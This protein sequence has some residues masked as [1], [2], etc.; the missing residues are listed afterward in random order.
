MFDL[1][2]H[3]SHYSIPTHAMRYASHLARRLDASLTAM[4]VHE[5]FVPIGPAAMTAPAIPEI[6]AANQCV[7]D[8]AIAAEGSF[9]RWAVEQGIEQH[10]W[11]VAS[12]SFSAAL[13]SAANWHDALILECGPA[14]P[15]GAVAPLGHALLT[16]GAP[17]FVVPDSYDGGA[18]L[19]TVV[20]ASN[21]RAEAV[22]AIHAALPIL[23]RAKRIELVQGTPQDDFFLVDFRPPF[24]VAALLQRH[25][26]RCFVRSLQGPGHRA[27]EEILSIAAAADADLV[28]MGAYGRTRASEWLLGGATRHMLEHARIPVFMR[29]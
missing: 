21:G 13:A 26:L 23:A 4:F 22:R 3:A 29:H 27:G 7:I 5:P 18:S 19:D 14:T 9:D 1:L 11:L 25:G 8:E 17:C 12:G 16:C 28:V 24:D 10:R 20:I 6:A 15:F 2:V